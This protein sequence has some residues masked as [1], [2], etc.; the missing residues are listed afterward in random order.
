MKG[1][2][3]ITR[4]FNKRHSEKIVV[5]LD[6]IDFQEDGIFCTYSPA[7][8]LV[9]YGNTQQE[10]HNSWEVVLAEYL[11]FTVENNTLQKD[12]TKHGWT[13]SN[14]NLTPPPFTWLLVHNDQVKD[15]YDNY[16]FTKSS[17]P[18]KVPIAA[19]C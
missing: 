2:N 14:D 12:L 3:K 7:L 15:F 10:A 13:V 16:N 5:Q 9:G 19:D 11:K 17:R 4:F 18:V 8:D 6:M 1:S